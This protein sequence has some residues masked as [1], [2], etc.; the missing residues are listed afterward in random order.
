M[1]VVRVRIYETGWSDCG[2]KERQA[3]FQ[4]PKPCWSQDLRCEIRSIGKFKRENRAV[5]I[6]R[7]SQKTRRS[8]SRPSAKIVGF[9]PWLRGRVPVSASAPRPARRSSPVRTFGGRVRLGWGRVGGCHALD[10]SDCSRVPFWQ[11][12]SSG[13]GATPGVIQKPP[14]LYSRQGLSGSPHN[15]DHTS[16]IPCHDS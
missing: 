16:P 11:R 2:E 4:M 3:E 8:G 10:R 1:V 13:H 15:P 9:T 12:R 14:R 5:H 7:P 6:L